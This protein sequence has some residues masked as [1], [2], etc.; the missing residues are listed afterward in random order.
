V[1]FWYASILFLTFG[2]KELSLVDIVGKYFLFLQF[3]FW[4][5]RGPRHS[6]YFWYNSVKKFQKMVVDLSFSQKKTQFEK[7]N[8]QKRSPGSQDIEVLKSAIF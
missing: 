2:I 7:K 5:K 4:E 6:R 1:V 3:F 8:R